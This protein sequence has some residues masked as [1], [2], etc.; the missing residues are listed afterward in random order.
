MSSVPVIILGL[1]TIEIKND[2]ICALMEPRV[3]QRKQKQ[4]SKQEIDHEGIHEGN[5]K[6][7]LCSQQ[8]AQWG[9]GW[10]GC[11]IK[12]NRECPSENMTLN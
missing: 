6:M 7:L 11:F 3:Q 1:N 12:E 9:G 2:R 4:S 10:E 8:G 5:K